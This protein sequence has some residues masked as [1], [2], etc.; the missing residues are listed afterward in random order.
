[1]SDVV[2][3]RHL[4]QARTLR[5]R[6]LLGRRARQAGLALLAALV[7][8]GLVYEPYLIPSASMQPALKRGDY[9]F[10]AKWPYGFGRHV[11]PLSP[12]LPGSPLPRL[13]PRLPD[14]GD[15]IVLKS[16]RD[17]RTDLVKRVIGL[18]GDL[19]AIHGGRIVL[20]NMPVP[21]RPGRQPGHV[22]ETLPDSRNITILD[23]SPGAMADFGPV[24]VPADHL[25]L[26][27][28][29]RQASIDSRWSPAEN[30]LGMVPFGHVV[31]RA[32][33]IIM[34]VNSNGLQADRIGQ[35]L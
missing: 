35:T 19:V 8:R 33:R 24:R 34:S 28:D 17:N 31:G 22:I 15:M 16:P 30:G 18:P 2:A 29:N 14:R 7:L 32:D 3:A 21:R 11:L 12:T 27:G 13:F 25:F 1:M 26:L 9:I 20:N 23:P 10:V 6:A 4:H 5:L